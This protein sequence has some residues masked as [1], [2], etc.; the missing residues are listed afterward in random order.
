MRAATV[1]ALGLVL[2]CL[3]C[4]SNDAAPTTL[5]TAPSGSLQALWQQRPGEDVG[6]VFGTNDYAPG[7]ARVSFLVVDHR[8]RAILRPTARVWLSRGLDKAPFRTGT[9]KL[10][11][12]GGGQKIYVTTLDI[13]TPGT[14]WLLAE[15]VGGYKIQGVG[16][17]V[18]Q[19]ESKSPAIGADAFP[20]KNPTLDDAPAEQITTA[21]PPDTELL[22]TSV[23]DAL[24]RHDP[25]VVV[26]ATPK[27]CQSRTCGPVVGIVDKVRTRFA[28]S[29]VK[30]IH[31]EV[32]EG[33]NPALGENRWFKEW[34][35]QS[36]PWVFLVGRDG[37]IKAKFEGP[38]SERE[39]G[40]AVSEFLT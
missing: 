39:L 8:A 22:R 15:P 40:D 24:D 5:S 16:N 35:L 28:S 32:Y 19:D 6:L 27:Y 30:F 7:P 3:G 29:P 9:A 21:R 25:F 14:Y 2:G 18:V 17:V 26:F 37:K 4:G 23:K 12:I 38:V 33:N 13:G 36:E 10:E 1:L 11:D 34:K 20:S 31:V